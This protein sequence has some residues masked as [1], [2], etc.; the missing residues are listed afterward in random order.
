MKNAASADAAGPQLSLTCPAK[1]ALA[2]AAGAQALDNRVGRTSAAALKQPLSSEQLEALLDVLSPAAVRS[3]AV[4]GGGLQIDGFLVPANVLQV[5]L[6]CRVHGMVAALDRSTLSHDIN[7]CEACNAARVLKQ[8][9]LNSALLPEA[10]Q[11]H[12][13]DGSCVC[14][15]L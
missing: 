9:A 15:R 10:G 6:P 3:A 7:S 14:H 1:A 5:G 12:V 11:S 2:A 4:G 13:S 8:T